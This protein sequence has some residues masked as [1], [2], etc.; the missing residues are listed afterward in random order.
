MIRVFAGV[1][2]EDVD[3]ELRATDKLCR[4]SH[5]NI[6]QVLQYGQ[7]LRDSSFYYIDMELCEFSLARYIN[8]VDVPHLQNWDTIR[9]H[10]NLETHI[11]DIMLQIVNGVIFI[12]E[13]DEVHRDLSPENG[14]IYHSPNLN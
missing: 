1:N 11:C 9:V 3:N 5:P 10:G 8:G 12:H 4:S 6:V 13:H 7:L 2:K 14:T